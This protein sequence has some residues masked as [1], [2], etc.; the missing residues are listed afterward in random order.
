MRQYLLLFSLLIP[1]FGYSQEVVLN[2]VIARVG[3]EFILMNDVED[4]YLGQTRGMTNVPENLRCQIFEG[5]LLQ[6]LLTNQAKIDSVKVSDDQV[7]NQLN[8][9]FDRVLAFMN[10]DM[11]QFEEYYGKS[12]NEMKDELREDLKDQMMAEE[13]RNKIVE[14][15][16]I[17][18]SE[19][20]D[21]FNSIP[22]DSLPYYNAEVEYSELNYYPKPSKIE[23]QRVIDKLN[24]IR[25]RI[26]E[27]GESFEDLA[28]KFSVDGSANAGGDLGWAKRGAFVPEFEAAVFN[29]EEG[30]VSPIVE[31]EFGFHLI[32]LIERRGNSFHARHIL[33]KPELSDNDK[34]I[35]RQ[36]LDSIVQLINK[37][38]LSFPEAVKKF[39]NKNFPSYSN[40]GRAINPKTNTNFF[41]I[42]DLEPDVYFTL[43]T[44]KLGEISAPI[45]FRDPYGETAYRVLMLQSRTEPHRASL[46][47]DYSR[48]KE[49]AIIRKKDSEL[50]KWVTRKIQ[51]TFITIDPEW[52]AKCPYL[53]RWKKNT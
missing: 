2:K 7:E 19:V 17:T 20:V 23:R 46:E 4:N 32:Q 18:P 24:S 1:F 8:A 35:A 14:K 52:L 12:V 47:K 37:K 11:A 26:V 31:T 29:L 25:Q 33:I 9:R 22:H 48:I 16:N 50:E 36:A 21:Y 39:G 28:K 40:G 45:E 15:V 30:Q 10:N 13:M 27:Q 6:K 44:M 38:D 3:G 53:D 42:S 43:D 49:D 41:E 5:L 34:K 51:E